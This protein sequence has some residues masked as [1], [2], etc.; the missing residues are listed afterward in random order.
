[1]IVRF[2]ALWIDKVLVA[3]KYFL[4]PPILTPH[5]LHLT[6]YSVARLAVLSPRAGLSFNS[7]DRG[8]EGGGGVCVVN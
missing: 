4:P 8:G 3:F 6:T 1:M 7:A 2:Y 5:R